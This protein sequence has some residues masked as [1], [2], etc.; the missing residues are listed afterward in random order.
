MARA[1]E[2]LPA[3]KVAHLVYAA[4][5]EEALAAAASPDVRARWV[6]VTSGTLPNPWRTV[7]DYFEEEEALLEGC[8]A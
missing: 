4:S 2:W 6:Y 5:R 1:P 8:A 7:P 3:E